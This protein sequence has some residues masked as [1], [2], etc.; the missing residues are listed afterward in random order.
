M[1][2]TA[3]QT[4]EIVALEERFVDEVW[5]DKNYDFIK[6][7]HTDDYVGHWFMVD[8]TREADLEDLEAFIRDVHDAF[9]DFT[10]EIEFAMGDEDRTAVGF[11]VTGTHDG[12]YMG[13]PPTG[14]IGETHGIMV[15]RFEDGKI[16]E[17]WAVWDALGQFQQLGV[18]PK[19]FTLASFLET[20]A[21]LAKQDVLKL[22]K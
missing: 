20:G 3:Q 8:E 15:H 1:A 14:K 21:T 6:E 10:M 17:A 19:E 22:T 18:I 16:V 5:N 11:T 7:I 9:P 13:I 2:T 4:N 12:E